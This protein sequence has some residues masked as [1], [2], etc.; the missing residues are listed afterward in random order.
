M[1]GVG[2]GVAA[3]G[4]PGYC[5]FPQRAQFGTEAGFMLPQDGQRWYRTVPCSF[6][7][8]LIVSAHHNFTRHYSP[9]ALIQ[10]GLV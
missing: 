2:G 5:G 1:A 10:M 8:A 6:A 4:A 3:A 9:V 7:S